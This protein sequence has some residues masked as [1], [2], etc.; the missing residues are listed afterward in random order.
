VRR[1]AVLAVALALVAGACSSGSDDPA[2]A[3][4]P[5]SPTTSIVTEADVPTTTVAPAS[6]AEARVTYYDVPAGSRPLDVAPAPDG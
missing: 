3:A 5:P 2:P 1:A 6:P 4:Q